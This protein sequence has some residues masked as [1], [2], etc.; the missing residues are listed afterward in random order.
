M[1]RGFVYTVSNSQR[2][3][4]VTAEETEAQRGQV[5]GPGPHS[6]KAEHLVALFRSV[7]LQSLLA[8]HTLCYGLVCS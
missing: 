5:T 2:S 6:G 3:P 1:A 7:W 4:A 8:L